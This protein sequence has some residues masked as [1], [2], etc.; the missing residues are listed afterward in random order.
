MRAAGQGSTQGRLTS[1]TAKRKI[2]NARK[3]AEHL[4]HKLT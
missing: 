2:K 3:L 4:I 1:K